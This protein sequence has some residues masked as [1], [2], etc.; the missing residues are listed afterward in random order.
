M[1]A[2][3][4]SPAGV[5]GDFGVG[6]EILIQGRHVGVVKFIGEPNQRMLARLIRS[7]CLF[8]NALQPTCGAMLGAPII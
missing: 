8:S 6:D 5:H 4:G 7:S 3:A 1:A 2:A